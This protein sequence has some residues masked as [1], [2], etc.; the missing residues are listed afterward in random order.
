MEINLEKHK[1]WRISIFPSLMQI[2]ID[3]KTTGECGAFQLF[4]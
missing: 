2:M 4:R 3:K 1:V